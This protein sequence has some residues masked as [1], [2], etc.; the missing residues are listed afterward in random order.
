MSELMKGFLK[1]AI[2]NGT[3]CICGDEKKQSS[4]D[5]CCTCTEIR[6]VLLRTESKSC[7]EW[8]QFRS[9][10]TDEFICNTTP[11]FTFLFQGPRALKE[12]K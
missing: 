8:T 10:L 6:E 3:R 7:G 2:A 12:L 11:D 9:M 1:W 5:D 4:C